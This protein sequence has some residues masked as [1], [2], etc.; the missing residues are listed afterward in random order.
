MLKVLHVDGRVRAAAALASF[1][2]RHELVNSAGELP[3]TKI[4]EVEHVHTQ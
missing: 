1:K 4:I 2:V 3:L